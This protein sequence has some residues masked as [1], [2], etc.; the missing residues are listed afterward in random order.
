MDYARKVSHKTR[1][2]GR[3]HPNFPAF[4]RHRDN[5][6]FTPK[7]SKKWQD[8]VLAGYRGMCLTVADMTL[9]T[10]L[11]FVS[12]SV[13]AILA[14]HFPLTARGETKSPENAQALL[15]EVK[16]RDFEREIAAKQ[17]EVNRLNEDLTKAQAESEDLKR[18]IEGIGT[19]IDDTSTNLDKLSAERT[20]LSQALE[21]AT[22]RVEAEKLKVTGY[23]M[24]SEGQKKA[25]SYMSSRIESTERKGA[26]AAAELKLASKQDAPA[27]GEP[28][29]DNAKATS[30]ANETETISKLK[31]QIAELR[32][33]GAKS[34]QALTDASHAADVA[35]EAASAKLAQADSAA[36]KA[37]KR[38][39]ELGLAEVA[40]G[41]G[42]KDAITAPKAKPVH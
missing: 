17:I 16:K 21:V 20:R 6:Q 15:L 14:S 28:V 27:T 23:K 37:N 30:D 32:K 4:Q 8:A 9:K 39:D 40:V 10:S 11:Q 24:L 35:I 2:F 31:S 36:A 12:F 13:A 1:A 3:P 34:Q 38:A 18:S 41:P 29:L 26:I 25:L 33:K 19:A 5:P 42:E 22:L 7:P